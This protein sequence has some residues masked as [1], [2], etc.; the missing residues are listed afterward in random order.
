MELLE[1]EGV[2]KSFG[3]IRAVDGVSLSVERGE[4]LA[5]LGPNGAG[6]T[7]LLRMALGIIHPDRG[8]VRY[9]LGGVVS[10]RPDPARIGYLP[11]ER[12]LYQDVPVLRFLTYFGALRGMSRRDARREA[13]R[14]LERLDLGDRAGEELRGLSKG[15]QQKVQFISSIVHSP[16]LALLDE[17]FSGLDPLNQDFFL[18]LIGELRA[19]G[20]TVVLSAHHMQLVE[21]LADRIVLV[22]SGRIA[23]SGTISE[24]RER[25]AAGRRLRLRVAGEAD[26]V[27][28]GTLPD[29]QE[30]R[31][32]APGEVVLEVGRDVSL[33][34][35]LEA[36]GRLV[37][38]RELTTE[39]VTLHDIYLRTVG[40][41]LEVAR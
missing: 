12:G 2:E 5:L 17:P 13:M 18:E 19:A 6:K 23:G 30:V 1:L 3:E 34:P 20:T 25:W 14:W 26:A 38:V 10:D 39:A 35:L 28:L 22:R 37:D 8:S 36:V 11:E 32:V 4:I 29:V 9:R 33:S 31:V 41:E 21:R 7:T 16:E 24:L 15:N 27:L 40:G